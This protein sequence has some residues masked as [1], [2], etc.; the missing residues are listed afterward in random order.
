MNLAGIKKQIKLN[1]IHDYPDTIINIK[2]GC[3]KNTRFPSGVTGKY[4]LAEVSGK[5]YHTRKYTLTITNS[6]WSFR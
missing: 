3:L 2:W 5:G 4:L 6:G 1:L